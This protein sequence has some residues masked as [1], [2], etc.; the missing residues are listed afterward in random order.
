M[1]L[2]DWLFKTN[3]KPKKKE[4][5]KWVRQAEKAKKNTQSNSKRRSASYRSD[6]AKQ[7]TTQSTP[8]SSSRRGSY[9]SSATTQRAQTLSKAAVKRQSAYDKYRARVKA[10]QNR[11]DLKALQKT[12]GKTYKNNQEIKPLIYT[13]D[14]EQNKE[15]SAVARVIDKNA[16]KTVYDAKTG[17]SKG[18]TLKEYYSAP[19]HQKEAQKQMAQD[20]KF[21]NEHPFLAGF[22]SSH[23]KF[24]NRSVEDLKDIYSNVKRKDGGKGINTK[25]YDKS[26]AAKVGEM[27]GTASQYITPSGLAGKVVGKTAIKTA[28][29]ATTK[30][31]AKSGTKRLAKS[32]VKQL[33]KTQAKKTAKDTV[34]QFAKRRAAEVAADTPLDVAH[35]Y[36][37]SKGDVKEFGK[38][39][40]NNL[41]MNVTVGSGM[42]YGGKALKALKGK[43]VAKSAMKKAAKGRKE[44]AKAVKGALESLENRAKEQ[45]DYLSNLRANMG[46]KAKTKAVKG[47]PVANKSVK[48]ITMR[49]TKTG[50]TITGK[51]RNKEDM[52]IML[53]SVSQGADN[54][55]DIKVTA[56][57][58]Q[59]EI[60]RTSETPTP[61]QQ[62]TVAGNG[63]SNTNAIKDPDE[64][65]REYDNTRAEIEDA[66]ATIDNAKQKLSE[67]KD[68]TK[69]AEYARQIDEAQ[70]KLDNSKS[71]L[72]G[73]VEN[74][75]EEIR[76]ANGSPEPKQ[77]ELPINEKAPEGA[78]PTQ[79][80]LPI[81]GKT[82]TPK[83]ETPKEASA[84]NESPRTKVDEQWEAKGEKYGT[85]DKADT[86]K[87]VDETTKVPKA[88]DTAMS[89][90]AGSRGIVDDANAKQEIRRS[91]LEKDVGFTQRSQ[92]RV[93]D[94]AYNDVA[95][96]IDYIEKEFTKA[97][98]AND[99][100]VARGIALY[101][102]YI[103]IGDTKKAADI[104]TDVS[105]KLVEA[106]RGI[107]AARMLMRSTPEG[108][109]RAIENLAKKLTEKYAKRMDGGKLTLSD[110]VKQ[111]LLK[112]RTQSEIMRAQKAA[113]IELYNQIPA[114]FME[115][116]NA[117]RYL[118]MLGNPRTHIRNLVGNA[119]FVIPR[120]IKNV[121]GTGLEGI[122]KKTGA[123]KQGDATKAIINFASK[124]DRELLAFGRKHF[125][126]N[127]DV[128]RGNTYRWNDNT[129]RPHEARFFGQEGK[130][131]PVKIKGKTYY[132]SAGNMLEVLRK[133]NGGALDVEDVLFMRPAYAEQMAMY[134]K[135]NGLT[136]A[137]MTGDT[138]AK[139]EE[140]A[141][142]EAL[143]ATYRDMSAFS[144]WIS[145]QKKITPES[146]FGAK[147]KG[148]ALEGLIPF[149]KTPVNILRR[150]FEY[151]PIGLLQGMGKLAKAAKAGNS[152]AVVKAIDRLAAGM[153]GTAVTGLGAYLTK[154][155]IINVE[156]GKDK[157]GKLRK[158][159][160]EQDYSIKI[161]DG[162][163]TLDWFAPMSIPFFAGASFVD[164]RQKADGNSDIFG[165]VLDTIMKTM[166]PVA[167]MSMLQGVTDFLQ[168]IS[169]YQTMGGGE[170][171]VSGAAGL[172][173]NYAT[174][175]VPTAFGQAARSIDP[176]Q[177]STKST[178][179]SS[180]TRTAERTLNRV[181]A[182]IPWLSKTL[183]PTLDQWGN[184]V[185][186]GK[187]GGGRVIQN[188]L[189]PG[190]WKENKATALD[191]EILSLGEKLD[192]DEKA[193]VFPKSKEDYTIK[194]NGNDVQ[195]TPEALTKYNKTVGKRSYEAASTLIETAAYQKMK[196]SEK[197]KALEKIY[198]QAGEIAKQDTLISMGKDK[199]KVRTENWSEENKKAAKEYAK[200][201]DIDDIV[202][203][204]MKIKS[205]GFSTAHNRDTNIKAL[206]LMNEGNAN[207]DLYK[208]YGIDKRTRR[209]V[210]DY[211]EAG[212][213]VEE[214]RICQRN[215]ERIKDKIGAESVT[216]MAAGA[217]ALAIAQSGGAP[218]LFRMYDQSTPNSRDYWA[219]SVNSG[220]GLAEAGFGA[221]KRAKIYENAKGENGRV[222]SASAKAYLDKTNYSTKVKSWLFD[223]I[224]PW[225]TK[226]NPY[227]HYEAKYKP[228]PP[229]AVDNTA[230]QKRNKNL[231]P[232]EKKY[233]KTE[234]PIDYSSSKSKEFMNNFGANMD[235]E[236]RRVGEKL[237]RAAQSSV[238]GINA[239]YKND[240]DYLPKETLQVVRSGD[241]RLDEEALKALRRGGVKRILNN[242]KKTLPKTKEFED[243]DSIFGEGKEGSGGSGGG[244]YYRRYGRR[245][246]GRGGSGGSGSTGTA[247]K[248]PED[249]KTK[250]AKYTPSTWSP[251]KVS[252]DSGWTDAQIRKVY[253][254]LIN[255]GLSQQQ[256][257]ARIAQLWHTRFS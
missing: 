128:I 85:Y 17:T 210:K 250:D 116:F 23:T 203:A 16:D 117:M 149:A 70:T 201:H 113:Q 228:K 56:K 217:K 20:E 57:N 234:R 257:V 187:S 90:Q 134:M 118:S 40:R 60:P 253:N 68:Q 194:F 63:G 129:G 231:S 198:E 65:V 221:L 204:N 50:K 71:K 209:I 125:N 83:A 29:K 101:D 43:A 2:L 62:E 41:L 115:K 126:D 175:V 246:Y 58:V 6:T 208:F 238:R 72:D 18:Q 232:L 31:L 174:Q 254:T 224:A 165:D 24:V 240:K 131:I 211:R 91:V 25:K 248:K 156:V 170:T 222:S 96:D 42:E 215:L 189:S 236:R 1:G 152:E 184:P 137:D 14:P 80:E 107:S 4:R 79:E 140:I 251:T 145:N 202:D 205:M 200:N 74:R 220:K 87:Q 59:E 54:A 48:E 230:T 102:H 256:A 76:R 171:L 109:V 199:F 193:K 53:R 182:K 93:L 73:L 161:G 227:G 122:A 92:K 173:T 169:G 95:E 162:S 185:I 47:K 33:A 239:P 133:F 75:P 207:K 141:T 139:A 81:G 112:A 163:Y 111:M 241:A 97:N 244:G 110:D 216:T 247:T 100:T 146:K 143:R 19:E 179:K 67:T 197:A 191:K 7:R 114:S 164:A 119:G 158:G 176:I 127:A 138:L 242:A 181:V 106:G 94:K 45:G 8:S 21:I 195:L 98:V 159:T 206:V 69:A 51:P 36:K 86:P 105:E 188:Y 178:A 172:F 223:Q 226:D 103:N 27:L 213:S 121:I 144:T 243:N 160:G 255:Q 136:A 245:G 44:T 28:T 104:I 130:G 148:V 150:G 132:M 46:V 154:S 183:E 157:E 13:G 55:S 11:R 218:R 151:S 5:D 168:S 9:V 39:M 84:T 147:V 167:E 38:E 142:Q 166:N 233:W 82:E 22:G 219:R 177:R 249:I 212:G 26:T 77:E 190:Y 30:A 66:S 225:N 88:L 34:K 32:S 37:D 10:E 214:L 61:R 180:T 196:P 35:S 135:A 153:T 3:K 89:E 12:T 52:R 124:K 186:N 237:Y 108:R 235:K 252:T 120:E 155:G 64:W 49:N 192:E 78:K 99:I 229:V 15:Y 123:I